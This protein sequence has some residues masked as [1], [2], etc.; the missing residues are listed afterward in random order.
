MHFEHRIILMI[1][2]DIY[3]HCL[4]KMEMRLIFTPE[5]IGQN[6]MQTRDTNLAI[7]LIVLQYTPF[8]PVVPIITIFIN[9]QGH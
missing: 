2:N 4:M 3:I 9:E 5:W 7:N 8:Y 1:I 6:I